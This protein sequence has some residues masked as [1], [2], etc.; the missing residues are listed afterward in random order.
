MVPVLRSDRVTSSINAPITGVVTAG[1][2]GNITGIGV[3]GGTTDAGIGDR[4]IV[5]LA[6]VLQTWG[7]AVLTAA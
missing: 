1:A 7:V 2:T 6:P 5:V 4:H 3:T